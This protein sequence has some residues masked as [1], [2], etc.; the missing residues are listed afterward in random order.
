MIYRYV[1]KRKLNDLGSDQ[2]TVRRINVQ[3][4]RKLPKASLIQE[5]TKT[6]SPPPAYSTAIKTIFNTQN[7]LTEEKVVAP[8]ESYRTFNG[9]TYAVIKVKT[10]ISINLYYKSLVCL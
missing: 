1:K 9:R 10:C 2:D 6:I 4:S 8:V 3:P 5:S 7:S